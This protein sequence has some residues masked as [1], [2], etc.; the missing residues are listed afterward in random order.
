LLLLGFCSKRINIGTKLNPI[1]KIIMSYF[2]I[3]ML[4]IF[5]K[6]CN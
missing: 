6:K 1:R 5:F 3:W 2:L 4:T